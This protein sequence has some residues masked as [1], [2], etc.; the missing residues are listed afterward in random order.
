MKN[1]KSSAS[2]QR[3]AAT[4]ALH[5]AERDA[6]QASERVRADARFVE[7]TKKCGN[8]HDRLI[9]SI[10]ARGDC[11]ERTRYLWLERRTGISARAWKNMCNRQSQPTLEMLERWCLD[12]GVEDAEWIVT[13]KG[14]QP[15]HEKS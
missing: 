1:D 10:R 6:W 11:G 15:D 5:S 7:R 9:E 14:S 2:T 3:A 4:R 13:G 12:A 8:V